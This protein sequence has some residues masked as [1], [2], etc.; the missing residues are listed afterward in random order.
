MAK[1]STPVLWFINSGSFILFFSSY[2]NCFLLNSH[3]SESVCFLSSLR[4]PQF[5]HLRFFV[6]IAFLIF[7]SF[8]FISLFFTSWNIF[9][10]LLSLLLFF[11]KFNWMILFISITSAIIYLLI[12]SRSKS[13]LDLFLE[14]LRRFFFKLLIRCFYLDVL[15]LP[16]MYS[17]NWPQYS[18]LPDLT[19]P[20][21]Q[22]PRLGIWFYVPLPPF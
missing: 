13:F 22:L 15:Q 17:E 7:D 18:C 14:L 19:F 11:F 2:H 21:T 4:F 8:Y 10:K 9:C 20:T 12:I 5:L 3:P 16:Q 6:L 1:Y